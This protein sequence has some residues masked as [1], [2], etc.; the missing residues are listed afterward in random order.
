MSLNLRMET[1]DHLPLVRA[2]RGYA[3]QAQAIRSQLRAT[4]QPMLVAT[5]QSRQ[6]LESLARHMRDE[7]DVET[8][9]NI[10]DRNSEGQATE[11]ALFARAA[12]TAA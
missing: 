2:R 6:T 3:D 7:G 10:N 9:V 4:G 1:V 8:V 12:N 11:Y 5:A